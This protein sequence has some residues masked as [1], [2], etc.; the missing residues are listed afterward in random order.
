MTKILTLIC[1]L[2][3]NL[4]FAQSSED[5]QVR[6]VLINLFEALSE[7]NLTEMQKFMTPDI[8]IL[9][10][11]LIWNMDTLVAITAK[12]RPANFKRVNTID[13]FQTE[14]HGDFAFVSYNNKAD[15]SSSAGKRNVTWLESA[16]LVRSG[17]K[18]RVKLLHSTRVSVK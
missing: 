12:P 13:F 11:G 15:I 4:V 1:L 8:K 10:H 5:Q 14:V 9:E 6:Q 16:V 7:N 3:S 2:S 17:G 18:W